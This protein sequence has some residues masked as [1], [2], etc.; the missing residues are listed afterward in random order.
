MKYLILALLFMAT[1]VAEEA[2][3]F[4]KDGEII[5]KLKD[6]KEYKFSANEYKVVKRSDRVLNMALVRSDSKDSPAPH[7]KSIAMKHIISGELVSS[8]NGLTV[9]S[10]NNAT[11]IQTRRN[12]GLGIQYQYNFI[13]NLYIGGRIDTNGGAGLSIGFGL[14]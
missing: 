11:Y 2:P 6:G 1:A 14:K 5:V 10:D 3:N 13:D 8:D 12:L 9:N 4:L 7:V